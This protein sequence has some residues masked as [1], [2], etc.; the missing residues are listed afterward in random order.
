MKKITTVLVLT[1]IVFGSWGNVFAAEKGDQP[2]FDLTKK[3]LTQILWGFKGFWRRFNTS[4]LLFKTWNVSSDVRH[5][6]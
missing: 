4:W 1:I 3:Q 5:C 2:E 6:K